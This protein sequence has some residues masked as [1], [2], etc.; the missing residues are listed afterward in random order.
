MRS[1][2]PNPRRLMLTI[3]PVALSLLRQV[4]REAT[5]TLSPVDCHINPRS[6][7]PSRRANA[8]YLDMLALDRSSQATE[9]LFMALPDVLRKEKV[10]VYLS[11]GEFRTFIALLRKK[12]LG[13]YVGKNAWYALWCHLRAADTEHKRKYGKE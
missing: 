13:M 9:A 2:R 3:E 1:L 12:A 5:A 4:V 11:A 7:K 8:A 6:E 10:T